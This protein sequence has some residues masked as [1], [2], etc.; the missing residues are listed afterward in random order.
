MRLLV[1][2]LVLAAIGGCDVLAPVIREQ[3]D[4]PPRGGSRCELVER[5]AQLDEP[6]PDTL[7]ESEVQAPSR[8][9]A[10]PL[11]E[12]T[13]AVQGDVEVAGATLECTHTTFVV[14]VAPGEHPPMPTVRVT[15]GAIED[16]VLTMASEDAVAELDLSGTAIDRATIELEGAVRA[17]LTGGRIAETALRLRVRQ[18]IAAPEVLLDRVNA[19]DLRID[20]A[21]AS[22]R[23]RDAVAGRILVSARWLSI[24]RGSLRAAILAADHVE[25]LD[26]VAAST[27]IDASRFI[28]AGGTMSEC[29]VARCD[30]V[31]LAL[32]HVTGTRFA[33]CTSPL[34]LE[35]ASL[36]DVVIEGDVSGHGSLIHGAALGGS[37]VVLEQ[38]TLQH[39]A[40]CGALTLSADE[41]DCFSC[42]PTAPAELCAGTIGSV[43]RCPGLCASHCSVAPPAMSVADDCA[44]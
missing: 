35:T 5:C 25:L 29:F 9:C 41:L 22:V 30:A 21:G 38:G 19:T 36:A 42:E 15:G 43:V 3:R 14:S 12:R 34:E 33:A 26:V 18:P 44:E 11:V 24:E 7:L 39:A 2:A 10:S 20:A 17:R 8:I 37:S 1:V 28:A 40:L 27:R 16:A 6:P 32:T 23:L 13:I 31:T 4:P